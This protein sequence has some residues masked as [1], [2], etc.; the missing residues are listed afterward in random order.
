M[1][2]HLI[3]ENNFVLTCRSFEMV[4]EARGDDRKKDLKESQNIGQQRDSRTDFAQIS[5]TNL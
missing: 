5:V 1:K 2:I 4:V 3:C